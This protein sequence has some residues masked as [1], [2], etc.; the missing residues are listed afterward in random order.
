MPFD[1]DRVETVTVDSYGTLV[2]PFATVGA[3]AEHV[4]EARVERIA[5]EWRARSILY[6]MVGNAIGVYRPF[7]EL[8]REALAYA[9]ATNGAELSAEQ[10]D[11]VLSVYHQLDVF[12]DVREG[13]Q[14]I[15]EAGFDVSVLSNGNPEML[16][17]MVDH[18]ELGAVLADTISADEIE[19]FKPDPEIYRHGAARTG[20]P[21]DRVLHVAG[22]AFD[23]L[24]AANAGMQA[25]W[26]A[27]GDDR[28][29]SFAGREPHLRA[30]TFH[31]VAD[32]LGA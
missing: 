10:V 12:P 32:A 13:L 27:R 2:D 17:S 20:T 4:P 30:D 16:A 7:Y 22:P 23:V 5:V 18:A 26:L 19:R 8:N 6:T 31:D 11:D 15:T 25:A 28:W 21:I 14:R 29:E 24:G 3:L 9:A 1:P